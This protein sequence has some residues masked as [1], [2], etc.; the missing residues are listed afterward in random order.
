MST[1]NSS[2]NKKVHRSI[3]IL[4]L[5]GPISLLI[6][7]VQG[8]L[9]AMTGNPS[10]PTPNP[11]LTAVSGA[12]S[13]LQ[14]AETAALTRATGTIATRN[15]KRAALV[16]LLEVLRSY[17][18]SVADASPENAIS[19]I[20]S[21]GLALR[22]PTVHAPRVFA[23]KGGT[24]SGSVKL[25]APIGGRR[26]AYLW[27]YSTDAGKT[28]VDVSPTLQAKATVTGLPAGTSVQFRYRSVIKG[29]AADWSAP[30]SLLVH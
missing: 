9:K 3:A 30:I 7:F 27:Q 12:V 21:A 29:G 2:T 26:A 16:T 5:P 6:T 22:K 14:V 17:V 15:E 23:A 1:N 24:V 25:T 19:I 10:F 18:Q 13:D 4:K 11:P 20:E 8:I 28:W